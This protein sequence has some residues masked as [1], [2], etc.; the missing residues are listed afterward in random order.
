MNSECVQWLQLLIDMVDVTG[1]HPEALFKKFFLERA[2]CK[3]HQGFIS[4]QASQVLYMYNMY[5][6]QIV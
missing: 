5:F 1:K 3:K 2:V 6:K 4:K